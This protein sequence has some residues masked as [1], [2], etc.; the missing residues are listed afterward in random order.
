[1]ICVVDK[2][3]LVILGPTARGNGIVCGRISLSFGTTKDR[4]SV[5]CLILKCFYLACDA[6]FQQILALYRLLK[7]LHDEG[8]GEKMETNADFHER[9]IMD[10]MVI[11]L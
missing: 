7:N 6:R 3:F 8:H 2:V 10:R 1:M 9:G 11:I 4:K 5:Y